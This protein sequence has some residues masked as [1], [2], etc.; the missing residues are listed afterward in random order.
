[1]AWWTDPLPAARRALGHL[2]AEP[3][4]VS[5]I[6]RLPLIALIGLLVYVR[7]VE[8]WLPTAYL[9]VF[10]VYA[11]AAVG[12]LVLVSGRAMPRWA[13]WAPAYVDVLVVSSL[14][15]VSGA[16][17]LELLPVFF[18]IP[19]SVVFLERP[20]LVAV[21]GV[22]AA[23]GYLLAWFVYARREAVLDLAPVIY[24]QVGCLLW[25]AAATTALCLVLTRRARRVRALVDV[26]RTLVSEVMNAEDRYNRQVAEQ[27]HDGP[28]QNLLAARLD[29]EEL[30]EQPGEAA[31][32]RVDN[33][34]RESVTALRATVTTLHPQVLAQ[35]GLT[36]A[37]A[38]L[39]RR[40]TPPGGP[41][42]DAEVEEV[43]RPAGQELLYRAAR[44]LLANVRK[45]ARARHVRLRLSRG[46]GTVLLSVAD[47]GVGFDLA[48]LDGCVAAGHIG[49]SSLLVGIEAMG[50]S[51]QL[52]SE[53]GGGTTVVVELPDT[54]PDGELSAS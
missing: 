46:A 19:V 22:G 37:V 1:M 17:T 26:R 27:L 31:L 40:Y 13:D 2:G 6:L 10:L 49:L 34:L 33:A 44:E 7:G 52:T 53:P 28:L 30:R 15:V 50:G 54:R 24:V 20:R 12:W 41:V 35:V 32:Q 48:A 29:L 36:A 16:A 14:C 47:D 45:H 38:D 11:V 42:V 9:A 4:R 39:A 23:V 25:F 21:L 3:V 51:V 18:M 8:H 5:A 43:G